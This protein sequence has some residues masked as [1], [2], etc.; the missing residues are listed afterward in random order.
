MMTCSLLVN[1]AFLPD[2]AAITLMLWAMNFLKC[3]ALGICCSWLSWEGC[4]RPRDM[5]RVS[6]AN[7]LYHCQI[8]VPS[9]KYTPFVC[10][11]LAAIWLCLSDYFYDRRFVR[12]TILLWI[13][14]LWAAESLRKVRD[15]QLTSSRWREAYVTKLLLAS[16][17]EQS[18][19]SMGHSDVVDGLT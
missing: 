2:E 5:V 11:C 3:Y 12:T 16:S 18:S 17:L 14:T 13:L 4:H 19:V 1:F 7:G 15:L 8:R 10:S 9:G 6:L